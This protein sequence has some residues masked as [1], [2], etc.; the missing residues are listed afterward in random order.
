M[1]TFLVIGIVG[2]VLVGISLVLGDVFDGVFD[3][4]AGDVFSSAVLGGFVSARR[5]PA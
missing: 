3:A 5:S 1:T 2:L 4:L